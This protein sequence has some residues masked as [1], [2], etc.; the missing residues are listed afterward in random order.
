MDE[1]ECDMHFEVD[2]RNLRG[3]KDAKKRR[4]YKDIYHRN[5][6]I[7]KRTAH[8]EEKIIYS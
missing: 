4:N 7:A 6:Q 5:Q 2:N 1:E 8:L 3:T